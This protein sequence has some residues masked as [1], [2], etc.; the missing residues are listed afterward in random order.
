[1]SIKQSIFPRKPL[2]V[3]GNCPFDPLP[4]GKFPWVHV[5]GRK[6]PPQH[7]DVTLPSQHVDPPAQ[8]QSQGPPRGVGELGTRL[9]RIRVGVVQLCGVEP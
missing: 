5:P 3:K 8:G 1:M 6:V 9:Y 7:Q 2:G 4:V